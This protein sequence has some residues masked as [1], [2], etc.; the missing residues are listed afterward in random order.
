[1]KKNGK[2]TKT[3][4]KLYLASMN[5]TSTITFCLENKAECIIFLVK[6]K[7][8]ILFLIRAFEFQMMISF[9]S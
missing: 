6:C 7:E 3:K 4:T 2:T 1:M 9:S 8:I 5:A